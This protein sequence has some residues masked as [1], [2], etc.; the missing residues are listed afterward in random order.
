MNRFALRLKDLRWSLDMTM[1]E[2]A[3]SVGINPNTYKNYDSGHR[4]PTLQLLKRL[5]LV[6]NINLNDWILCI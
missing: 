5:V 3:K 2:F 4:K 6:Y 1:E